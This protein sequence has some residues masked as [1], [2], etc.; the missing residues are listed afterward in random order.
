MTIQFELWHLILLGSM[1]LGAFYGMAR[2][3]LAQAR[4][5][6]REKFLEI[7]ATLRAQ[8]DNARRLERELLEL[9]RDLPL[10]YVRREDYIPNYASILTK[11][12]ALNLNLEAKFIDLLRSCQPP[13]PPGSAPAPAAAGAV[14]TTTEYVRRHP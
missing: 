8:D 2:M 10:Y 9:K 5:A 7:V 6:I 11:I 14:S 1:I 12:D 3:L 4:E 13:A